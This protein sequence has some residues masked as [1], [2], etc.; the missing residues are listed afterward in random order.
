MLLP[1]MIREWPWPVVVG[2]GWA[3]LVARQTPVPQ[4]VF[5]S[6]ASAVP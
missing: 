6:G 1:Q 3:G 5:R 2:V 4:P